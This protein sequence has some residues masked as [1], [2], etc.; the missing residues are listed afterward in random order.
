MNIWA[1]KLTGHACTRI[2]Y[3]GYEISIAMDDSCGTFDHYY[4][5]SIAVYLG[6][7]YVTEQFFVRPFQSYLEATG[8]ELKRI[9]AKIDE[10]TS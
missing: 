8:E 5:S 4:R 9:F 1:V 3:K 7:K 10:L 6:E 2:P